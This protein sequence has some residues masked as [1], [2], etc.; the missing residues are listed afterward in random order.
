MDHIHESL[1]YGML[2]TLSF[3][4]NLTTMQ[5]ASV[6]VGDLSRYNN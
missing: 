1:F 6:L 4:D 5:V 3:P 2:Q